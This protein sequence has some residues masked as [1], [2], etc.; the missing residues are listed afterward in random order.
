MIVTFGK[1][2]SYI[3]ICT[4][5]GDCNHTARTEICRYLIWQPSSKNCTARITRLR[6]YYENFGMI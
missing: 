6:T 4:V 1:A 2:V 3:K 5:G